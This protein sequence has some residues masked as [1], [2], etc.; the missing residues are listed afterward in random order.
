MKTDGDPHPN[1]ATVRHGPNPVG[2]RDLVIGDLH[3]EFDTLEHALETL[4]FQPARD[5]LFTVGDLIDRGPRSAD[6]LEWLDNGR[7]AG[8]VRGNHE[9]MMTRALTSGEAV[10]MRMSGPGAMWL[11]N[12]AD[13]WYESA[14]ISEA[15]KQRRRTPKGTLID[16]W[17]KAMAGM[18]YL[19]VIEY[20][21]RRVGLVHSPGAADDEAHWEQLW[22]QAET[23][24]APGA[25]GHEPARQQLEYAL[26]W[27][28]PR[29]H[30]TRHDDP[31]LDQ[32]LEGVD[33]VIAGHTPALWPT[34]TRRNVVSLDTGA[35]YEGLGHLTVAEIQ[36][37]LTLHRFA[38]TET[39]AQRT[40][41][42]S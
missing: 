12:G 26:L 36:D 41:E 42:E 22:E 4:G 25:Q 3:G 6:A 19:T 29:K 40:T 15:R 5:R 39:F 34:W 23:V 28:D 31:K 38:R 11:A 16:R 2:G 21:S 8:S 24:P 32:A 13:W 1:P 17:L 20:G 14:A 10:L 9:Q 30:A 18:P 27:R 37:G 33:L 35:H 7:F